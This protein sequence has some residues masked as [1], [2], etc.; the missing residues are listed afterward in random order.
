MSK[1]M[2]R[3]ILELVTKGYLESD[4]FNGVHY[5][6]IQA[7]VGRKGLGPSIRR[8]IEDELIDVLWLGPDQNPAIRRYYVP[9]TDEQLERMRVAKGAPD[10]FVYPGRLHLD[11]VVDRSAYSGEPYRLLLALGE[12][13]LAHRVFDLSVLEFYRNDPRYYYRCQ[14]V[15]GF[16]SVTDEHYESD[17]MPGRDKVILETFGFA[18]NEH[19]DRAVTTFV[20]YLAKLS[21]EHQQIWK[22]KELDGDYRLH[23]HFS[24]TQIVGNFAPEI[25]IFSA[26]VMEMGLINEMASAMGRPPMFRQV[27][28]PDSLPSGFGFLLRPT[29]ADF[30]DFVLLFDKMLSDNLDKGF[31]M[32]EVSDEREQERAD[33][34]IVV[35]A[36]GTLQ[37]LDEWARL[38]FRTNDWEPFDE[39][40]A[41]FR[42]LR[43]LRQKPA[44]AVEENVF[45]QR[46]FRDQ[47]ALVIAVYSGLRIIRLMFAN[48]PRAAKVSIHSMLRE[49][50]ICD[51]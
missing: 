6:R 28:D 27:L 36:K 12:R 21:P 1:D 34:K 5:A 13:Q 18:Y 2:E 42:K 38:K 40:M 7:A 22:A 8:L 16:I 48:H 17:A 49:G 41:S 44:H 4:D 47:R 33:G 11:R 37:M 50:K 3:S 29:L 32:G 14:D 23:P 31:F 15:H 43:K 9:S 30:N 46:Y 20:C 39:A 35:A 25:G 45:D 24:T 19:L 51:F 10:L 26:V